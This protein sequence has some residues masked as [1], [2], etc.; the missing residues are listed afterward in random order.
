L[1]WAEELAEV[2][3]ASK[4]THEDA[5]RADVQLEAFGQLSGT[6]TLKKVGAA[7]LVVALEGG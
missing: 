2:R 1:G 5:N 7:N 4:V 3:V 6:E